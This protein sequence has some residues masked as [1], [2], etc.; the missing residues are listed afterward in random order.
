M[1]KGRETRLT[2]WST[3]AAALTSNPST[4]GLTSSKIENTK[5]V[6]RPRFMTRGPNPDM[7]PATPCCATMLAARART[8]EGP[9][10]PIWARVRR[11]SMGWV[12]AGGDED[13]G[14]DE[15]K[16]ACEGR[17][18]QACSSMCSGVTCTVAMAAADR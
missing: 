5:A 3:W 7:S 2:Q 14:D 13:E 12:T 18:V 9:D 4:R 1:T 17:E 15:D 6:C 16:G 10:R 11:T 8:P